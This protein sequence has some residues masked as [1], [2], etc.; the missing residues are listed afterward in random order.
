MQNG[1]NNN[2]SS[3]P[4]SFS[5]SF[6]LFRFV[7]CNRR[8]FLLLFF[9]RNNNN[10]WFVYF[11]ISFHFFSYSIELEIIIITIASLCCSCR[12]WRSNEKPRQFNQRRYLGF[13]DRGR[14][15]SSVLHPRRRRRRRRP[16]QSRL[17]RFVLLLPHFHFHHFISLTHFWSNLIKGSPSSLG[18]VGGLTRNW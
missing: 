10:K 7:N 12:R 14:R 6:S 18:V 8:R 17:L 1:N 9:S 2:I 3:L 16:F 4:T 11:Y 15:A 13:I 5:S